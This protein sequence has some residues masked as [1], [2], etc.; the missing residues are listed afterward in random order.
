MPCVCKY[1]YDWLGLMHVM[2][3]ATLTL[4]PPTSSPPS[5]F[6]SQYEPPHESAESGYDS[7]AAYDSLR[8]LLSKTH[9]SKYFKEFRRREV[10]LEEL[11]LLTEA[12]LTEVRPP[13]SPRTRLAVSGLVRLQSV[14]D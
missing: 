11:K 12:D 4:S 1:V 7:D 10:R 5:L 6:V 14:Q 2:L 3:V 9:L 8:G 13:P